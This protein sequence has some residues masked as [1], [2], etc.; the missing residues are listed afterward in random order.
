MN[1][2]LII[3]PNIE[4][5]GIEKNLILLSS[6]LSNKSNITVV[7]SEISENIKKSLDGKIKLFIAKQYFKTTYI[8]KNSKYCKCFFGVILNRSDS[9]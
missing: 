7:C 8:P 3:M 9:K 6:Y 5:G 2:I 1:N 4:N